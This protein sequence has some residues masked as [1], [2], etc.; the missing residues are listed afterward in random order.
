MAVDVK[1]VVDRRVVR[2]DTLQDLLADAE[3]LAAGPVR[4][5]G[6]HSFGQILRH[7]ALTMNGSIDD[8]FS[9]IRFPWWIRFLA[10]MR[11]KA[12]FAGGL[13]P[14]IRLPSDAD[15]YAWPKEKELTAMLEDLRKAVSRLENETKR[16]SHP[17]FGKLTVNEW[18]QF[19]LRHSELH[20]SF[21]VPL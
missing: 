21:V 3:Q 15:V 6:N 7:L 5:L 10:R 2:Y 12:I 13:R 14:G 9:S 4:T 19:H 20:M 11:R 18:N 8:A 1:H 16:G 17:A